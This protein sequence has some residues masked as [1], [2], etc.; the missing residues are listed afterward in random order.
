MSCLVLLRQEMPW[1]FCLAFVRAG[2]S[3]AARMAMMAMTT[4]SS[5][6]VKAWGR[7]PLRGKGLSEFGLVVFI[8]IVSR[9]HGLITGAISVQ[10]L[11]R[12]HAFCQYL[13]PAIKQ[14]TRPI[15]Q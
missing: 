4:S 10:Q 7:R 6:N 13:S 14:A 3:I 11:P 5:I 2:R 8:N 12:F 15:N 9:R 1:V